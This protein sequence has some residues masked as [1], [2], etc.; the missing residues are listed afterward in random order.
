MQF[1]LHFLIRYREVINVFIYLQEKPVFMLPYIM[2]QFI[3]LI[4]L[5]LIIFIIIILLFQEMLIGYGILV[6]LIGGL[7]TGKL[8]NPATS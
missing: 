4:F 7:V 3:I 1:I 2:I 6:L 8:E 5:I